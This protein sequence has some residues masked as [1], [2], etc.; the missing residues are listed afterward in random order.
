MKLRLVVSV[1]IV[2][3]VACSSEYIVSTKDG[4]MITTDGRPKLDEKTGM[5][6]YED[7]EGREGMVKKDD[8]VEILER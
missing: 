5:Y 8:V 6:R 2:G 7:D 4:R 1:L 3:L